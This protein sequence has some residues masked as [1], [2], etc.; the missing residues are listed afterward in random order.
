MARRQ[1]TLTKLVSDSLPTG[2][3][4]LVAVSGGKDSVVL[5]FSLISI[6][7]LKKVTLEVAHVDHGLR[8]ESA[9]DAE[10][11]REIAKANGLPFH[12]ATLDP[13]QLAVNL[14]SWGRHER[15]SFFER[16]AHERELDW[17][18]TAHTANDVAET[19]LMRL[20]ANKGVGNILPKDERRR[21]V[22]P[23]LRAT[24]E[25]VDEFSATHGLKWR[26]DSTNKETVF[27]RNRVRHLVL[28]VIVRTFGGSVIR[29]LSERGLALHEDEHYL[30][31]IAL[32]RV[33]PL[34]PLAVES[35][36]WLRRASGL[37]AS[38]PNPLRWRAAEH[39]LLPAV[40]YPIGPR[41]GALVSD[42]L[43]LAKGRVELG[44]NLQVT[45]T[46]KGILLSKV[47][48]VTDEKADR[49]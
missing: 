5:L 1:P 15:Y 35:S 23:M 27:T 40:G 36:E 13:P 12:L 20:F 31:G 28:P 45:A 19:L 48:T 22:R 7:H 34:L 10:F 49:G 21:V 11:V 8:S 42:L 4:V 24:R 46:S 26:E 30:S 47:E 16:V 29:A 3:K 38:L 39:I 2:A 44:G 32:E 33:T 9:A 18:L 17:I 43:I 37:F 6:I 41:R 25:Q 14:E